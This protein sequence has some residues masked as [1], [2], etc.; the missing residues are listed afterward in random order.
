[1]ARRQA[2]DGSRRSLPVPVPAKTR[3]LLLRKCDT[4]SDATAHPATAQG[5]LAR[6]AGPGGRRTARLPRRIDLRQEPAKQT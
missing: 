2:W 6:P 5:R 4:P 1:M 3:K